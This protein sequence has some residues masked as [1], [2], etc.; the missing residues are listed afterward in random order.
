MQVNTLRA[1]STYILKIVFS[2]EE[3]GDEK[4]PDDGSVL[5]VQSKE[6]IRLRKRC[7]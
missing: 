1:L 2:S 6:G 3:I 4:K 5:H 7:T